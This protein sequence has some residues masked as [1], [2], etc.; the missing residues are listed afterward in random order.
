MSRLRHLLED[1]EKGGVE[2]L[3]DEA[4]REL[5]QG[6]R[7]QARRLAWEALR[8]DPGRATAWLVLAALAAPRAALHYA[9]RAA[10][11]RPH[12]PVA[13]SAAEWARER[14]LEATAPH[15]RAAAPAVL[16]GP[17]P[18]RK[19][20]ALARR[21]PDAAPPAPARPAYNWSLA[22]GGL[23]VLVMAILA[24]AGPRLA[25][26]DPLK[27]NFIVK[28]GEE[29]V[30]PPFAPLAVPG[31]PLGAD[32][33]GRDILSQ[34]LWAVQPTLTLVL[35]VAAVRLLAGTTVGLL[36]GWSSGWGGRLGDG[37]ISAGLAAPVLFVALCVIAAAGQ[38]L[39]VWA[40]I[41]GLSITGWA[42]AGR[43]VREQARLVRAQP[44]IESA[45]AL[46]ASR[47]GIILRHGL[48]QIMPLVWMSLAFEVSSA[49]LTT[50]G[51]GFLGYFVYALW[52]P[53]EDFVGIRT[54]GRPEL[55]QMLGSASAVQSQPWAMLA[56]GSLVF[57]MVLGFN[58][59]G[60]G[61]QAQFSTPGRIR[62]RGPL[63]QALARAAGWAEDRLFDPLSPWRRHLQTAGGLAALAAIAALGGYALWRAQAAPA[64]TPAVAVPGGH[65]WAAEQHDAQGT[66][67]SPAAGPESPQ[68]RLLY[69]GETAFSGSP[70]VA[71]DGTLYAG[72]WAGQ[73]LA[74]GPDGELLWEQAL[75]DRAFGTP[76]LGPGG[77]VF[78]ADQGGGLTAV[79]PDGSLAW[80]LEA[81]QRGVA[82]ASPVVGPDGSVYF[83]AELA[84][85]ALEPDGTVRWEQTLPT[86]SYASPLP[87][88]SGDGRL[89]FFEDVVV[90]AAMGEVLYAET[91]EPLDKFVVGVDGRMYRRQQSM[92]LEFIPADGQAQLVERAR[93]DGR[94]LGLGFRFP[95]DAGV[96]PSGRTWLYF[97]SEFEF[98]KLAWLDPAGQ[99]LAPLDYPYTGLTRLVGIDVNDVAYVCGLLI[100][101]APA[102]ECRANRP[103]ESAPTWKVALP[104][105]TTPVG[106]ALGPGRLYVTLD[107]GLLYVLE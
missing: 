30:K 96:T 104:D 64:Q 69:A 97:E 61:L 43:L 95:L 83:A 85:L 47:A 103:G 37:L 12:D 92:L 11:A 89:L 107:E 52:I 46:G 81:S 3:L 79:R 18:E 10:E 67:W 63:G 34:L 20:E 98:P 49:L 72:T 21:K 23:V 13:R 17:A 75:P 88:L 55:G 44:F 19:A 80:Q 14:L 76:A 54:T 68:A 51:L 2:A 50:A 84:L 87:R 77:D 1:P 105:G 65:Q 86:F 82:L 29:F 53:I 57:L 35:V 7:M 71:A 39:G 93:W 15:R 4:R 94:S 40:F 99:P 8:I 25:P 101:D 78:M 28:A 106:G 22:L 60:D 32:E 16:S 48:P 42:E 102:A 45:R 36:S 66:L 70:A 6:R 38:R 90:D 58:L 62:R 5:G 74:I 59:L 41:L 26:R 27:E 56:A 33:F 31:F 24:V 9:E 100:Q 73:L 91:P